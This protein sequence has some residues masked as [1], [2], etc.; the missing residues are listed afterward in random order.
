MYTYIL[1]IIVTFRIL[2]GY[3]FTFSFT[4]VCTFINIDI[5]SICVVCF[6]TNV[7]HCAI[8][9]LFYFV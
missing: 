2:L 5:L 9:P 6:L 4:F 3:I 7:M 1:K 8:L